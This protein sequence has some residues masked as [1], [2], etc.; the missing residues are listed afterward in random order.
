ML[1]KPINIYPHGESRFIYLIVWKKANTTIV[2]VIEPSGCVL[3]PFNICFCK[4]K[5]IAIIVVYP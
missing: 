5:F 2:I 1:L 3:I 4:S